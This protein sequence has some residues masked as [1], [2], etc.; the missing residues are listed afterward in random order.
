MCPSSLSS[1][2]R[3]WVGVG[4]GGSESDSHKFFQ[5][6]G[7]ELM[8]QN[9]PGFGV[10][11]G[12]SMTVDFGLDV[13][14]FI[15]QTSSRLFILA[16][17]FQPG[18]SHTL[19]SGTLSGFIPTVLARSRNLSGNSDVAKSPQGPCPWFSAPVLHGERRKWEELLERFGGF[20][21]KILFDG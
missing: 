21:T 18:T 17:L 15:F 9:L 1:L 19:P 16:I 14:P 13:Y 3:Q 5:V 6:L 4:V 12:F 10:G 20:N 7:A 2:Q 11:V 8:C